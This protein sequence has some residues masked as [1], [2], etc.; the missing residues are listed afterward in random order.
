MNKS[1][2]TEQQ[3]LDHLTHISATNEWGTDKELGML[4]AS[5]VIDVVS[6]NAMDSGCDRWRLDP[7]YNHD[8]G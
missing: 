3:L 6:I 8:E 4:D 7:I 2:M 1:G 5:A